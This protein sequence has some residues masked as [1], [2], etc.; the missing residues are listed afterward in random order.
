[1][2]GVFMC[3]G[4]ANSPSSSSEGGAGA[5]TGVGML[6]FMTLAGAVGVKSRPLSKSRIS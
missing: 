2:V 5:D 4:A 6:L 3:A 1:M